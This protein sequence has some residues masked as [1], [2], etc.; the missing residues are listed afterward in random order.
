[1]LAGFYRLFNVGYGFCE[2]I[3][4]AI[5]R[6]LLLVPTVV[7]VVFTILV[8]V[9][10]WGFLALPTGF[11]PTEDQ[12]YVIVSLQLPDAASQTR[13]L[14]VG[15]QINDLIAKTPG[16]QAWTM[17]GGN[18]IFDGT[19]TSNSATYYVVFKDWKDRSEKEDQP[20]ILQHLRGS[21]QKVPGAVAITFPPPAIMGLGVS[22]GFQMQVNDIGGVGLT[23]LQ[24]V[25]QGMVDAGNDQSNLQSLNTT[26][27]MNVPQLYADIDRTKVKSLGISLDEVFGTLQTYLGSTYVNDFNAFNRTYQVRVQ[28]EG[29]FR[30]RPSDI[31]RLEVRNSAGEMVPLGALMTIKEQLGPQT[32]TR[33]NQRPSATITGQ[34]AP[35]VSSGD[36]LLLMEHLAQAELPAGMGYEW[37]AMSFQEKQV[38]SEALGIFGFAIL[39]VY[40]VLAAQYE[41]WT[42]PFAVILVV[43]LALL[44]T[45]IMVAVR[46]MDNNVYTQIG[47]VL[48]IALA[49]KNA[50][51]IVEFAR[52]LHAK[53]HKIADAA[54]EAAR[55]RFRPILMTSFA[56]ILGVV[57][58]VN[59]EGAGAASRQSLGTAVFG[60]MIASTVLAVFF[61]PVFY[62]VVQTFSEWL[63]PVSPV[64]EVGEPAKTAGDGKAVTGIQ[65]VP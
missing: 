24:Q 48:I 56:F 43:P 42:S 52:E 11:L 37:T 58:L 4:T 3:Y 28:A 29:K 47:V 8:A 41:S 60:G 32:I 35:G 61:V 38:G 50:I 16:V 14:V 20:H 23:Q 49:S 55:S 33:Y 10:F 39:L 53:G 7:M 19:T 1:M 59:A 9:T 36:A 63:S 34:A 18:N 5:V 22:G 25:A 64:A 13:T 65:A 6:V 27:S 46:G 51:L 30:A 44:G 57:P 40:C 21:F 54:A 45:V 17:V 12:G 2:R 31:R 15:R 26:F 62:L